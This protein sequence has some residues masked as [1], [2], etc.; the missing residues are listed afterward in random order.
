MRHLLA[1]TIAA[2]LAVGTATAQTATEPQLD[3][4]VIEQDSGSSAQGIFVP[5]FAVLLLLLLHIGGESPAAVV[6]TPA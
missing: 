4:T 3:V 6:I 2:G 5:I 1:L